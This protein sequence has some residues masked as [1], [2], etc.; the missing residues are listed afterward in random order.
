MSQAT[1][2]TPALHQVRDEG[3]RAGQ[4]VELGDHQHG[5]LVPAQLQRTVELGPVAPPPALNFGVFGQQLA[6]PGHEGRDGGALSI[7]AEPALPLA[8]GRDAV[9][10]DE[11]AHP[12]CRRVMREPRTPSLVS[13]NPSYPS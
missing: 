4:P 13:P 8:V 3:D 2:S 12:V 6:P 10:G 1:N 5:T 7:E 11:A 9:V